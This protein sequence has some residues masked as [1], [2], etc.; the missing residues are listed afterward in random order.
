M[1]VAKYL[2]EIR[3]TGF[4]KKYL[5]KLINLI[6]RNFKIK[7]K[8]IPHITLVGPFYTKKE[9]KLINVFEEV[10]K[11][12]QP[13]QFKLEGFGFFVS[14]RVIYFNVIAQKELQELR[15]ELVLK[16]ARFC[17][18]NE[19]DENY[20]YKF[21]ATICFKV[22]KEKFRKILEFVKNRKLPSISQFITRISIIKNGKILCEYDFFSEKTFNKKRSKE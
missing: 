2:I 16:L 12:Y 3:L 7:R 20:T 11:K 9:S 10:M 15:R 6:R 18:L 17:K 8:I 21:H 22:S 13:I 5:R 14:T 19:F 4:S 1:K